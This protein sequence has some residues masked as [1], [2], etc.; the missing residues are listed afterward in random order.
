MRPPK[1]ISDSY[2]TSQKHVFKREEV[3]FWECIFAKIIP[4][5]Q[6][7]QERE[8]YLDFRI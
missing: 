7:V 2:S 1:Q 4:K 8:K 3:P 6:A 5:D